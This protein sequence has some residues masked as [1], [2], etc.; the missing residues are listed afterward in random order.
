MR[1]RTRTVSFPR[2]Q[3]SP[4]I[5]TVGCL[6]TRLA[7]QFQQHVAL[8][9][10]IRFELVE[11][12][13]ALFDRVK[14]HGGRGRR[15]ARRTCTGLLRR[16]DTGFPRRTR[17]G[18]LRRNRSGHVRPT[19]RSMCKNMTCTVRRVGGTIAVLLALL[20]PPARRTD[21]SPTIHVRFVCIVLAVHV[22]RTGV[23][24]HRTNRHE[25]QKDP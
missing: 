6:R 23:R 21:R 4:L 9:Q 11:V 1:D 20:P 5:A 2:T 13:Q 12:T 7:G 10:R 14:R 3:P 22:A 16:T 8:T 25:D 18:L 15:R 17:T 19:Y 24:L